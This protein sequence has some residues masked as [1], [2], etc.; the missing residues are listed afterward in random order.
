MEKH[1]EKK[2]KCFQLTSK[3]INFLLSYL[4]VWSLANT[5]Q[6]Q[7]KPESAKEKFTGALINTQ[8]FKFGSVLTE[9][10]DES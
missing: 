7:V 8:L 3:N 5:N 2:G 6:C 10:G 9:L 1:Q 4:C